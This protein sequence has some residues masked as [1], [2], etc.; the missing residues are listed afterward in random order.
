M[1][2]KKTFL[3]YAC[4]TK[5]HIHLFISCFDYTNTSFLHLMKK[6]SHFIHF[7]PESYHKDDLSIPTYVLMTVYKDLKL[8][9]EKK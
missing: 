5:I 3:T 4:T 1:T 6:Q 2:F 8:K 7:Y 9:R